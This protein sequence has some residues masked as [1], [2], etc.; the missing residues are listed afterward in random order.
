MKIGVMMALLGGKTLEEALDYVA[1]KGVECVELCAGNYPGEPHFKSA[2][3]V[4][5]KAARERLLA[6]VKDR[7]L[8][9]S[10]F[11]CHGNPLH[12]NS[13]TA[14]KNHQVIRT[15]V[16]LARLCGVR[17]VTGFSGCPGG[18]PSDKTPNWIVSPW[19]PDY[20]KA[21]E[22]Q[23]KARVSPYWQREAKFA[24]DNG[25]R[26]AFEMHPG[27]VVYNTD[28]MQKLRE[29]C[30]KYG[31]VVGANF[32]PSHL[33]W[34]GTD[35]LAALRRLG[36]GMI[37]HVHAK[38]TRIDPLNSAAVGNLDM[39]PYDDVAGRS[40]VFRTVGYGHGEQFWR[41][42]VT[43]LRTLGYDGA[44]SIEHEDALMS[45]DE[46]FTKAVELLKRVTLK[47]KAGSLWW[48]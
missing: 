4:S 44:L 9:I 18:S 45:P 40:W 16:K 38:D 46:G 13:Q 14:K 17:T 43:T 1:E 11:A 19:P 7:G 25:V 23:W 15:A 33:W 37:F 3:L 8:K 24:A 28:S 41:E 6:A 32:D 22:W 29:A 47:T 20:Q 36:G 48:T 10:A 39:K 30:G 12:P 5:N 21:L 35:P 42:F 26:H 34:Q 2:E 27:F 31:K